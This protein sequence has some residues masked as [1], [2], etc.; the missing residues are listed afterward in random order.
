MQIEKTK[1]YIVNCAGAEVYWHKN[2]DPGKSKD[3]QL[4]Q[5][6]K[7]AFLNANVKKIKLTNLYP[8]TLSGVPFSSIKGWRRLLEKDFRDHKEAEVE[9]ELLVLPKD[10]NTASA[11]N[12]F[13]I[14]SI[15]AK[16]LDENGQLDG[17]SR[18]VYREQAREWLSFLS[19]YDSLAE[20]APQI[21]AKL[22]QKLLPDFF[23]IVQ[24]AFGQVAD[25]VSAL[26]FLCEN[27]ET[28]EGREE[29]L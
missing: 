1:L 16:G 13:F 3:R 22:P 6:F 17:K 9:K 11:L 14:A 26:L 19:G 8:S 4:A 2:F 15:I 28:S 20:M 29:R 10:A 12:E 7:K 25:S 23:R 21:A 18:E 27:N 5:A 24:I